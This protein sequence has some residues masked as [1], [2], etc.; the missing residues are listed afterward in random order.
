MYTR[1]HNIISV[2]TYLWMHVCTLLSKVECSCH[3][4]AIYHHMLWA[5]SIIIHCS[6]LMIS[7]AATNAIITILNQNTWITL[8]CTATHTLF[9]YKCSL[10]VPHWN[11][12]CNVV[13]SV[14]LCMVYNNC[15][16]IYW[17]IFCPPHAHIM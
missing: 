2:L 12:I 7:L 5:F 15:P 16:S 11:W 3:V 1:C 10:Q 6:K 14:S 9:C 17:F 4:S 8:L 13:F